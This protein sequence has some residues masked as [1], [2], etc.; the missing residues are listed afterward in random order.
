MTS[1]YSNDYQMVIK[2]L[3]EARIAC[4]ITQ[5]EVTSAF[6]RPQSFIAKVESGE[7]RLDVVEFVHFCRLVN[8]QPV[9]ILDK[10]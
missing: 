6:G 7:R 3:R 10:L 5:Q 4:G 9:S 8:I 1:I 2:A